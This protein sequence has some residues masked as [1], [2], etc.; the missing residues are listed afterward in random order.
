MIYELTIEDDKE[1]QVVAFLKQLD[2]VQLKKVAKSKVTLKKATRK[3]N[4]DLP[5][6]GS[7]LN[8]D[9]E[10][11]DLRTTANKRLTKW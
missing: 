8:W 2:F 11:S 9:V 5:Y 7:C 6:F 4:D 10:S 3:K 1:K